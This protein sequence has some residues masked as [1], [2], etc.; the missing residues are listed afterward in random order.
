[1]ICI[2]TYISLITQITSK[3]CIYLQNKSRPIPSLDPSI[4]QQERVTAPP[5]P[6][7]GTQHRS[8]GEG[9]RPSL[10]HPWNPA[11]VS[12]RGSTSLPTPPLEHSIC[13][14]ERVTVPPY[15]TPGTQHLSAGEGHR[16]SLPHPWNPASVSRRGSPSLPTSPLD[17]SICQQERVTVP[18]YLT[19][20]TQ[21]RSAGEGHRPSLPHPWTPASVSRRGSPPLPT[22]PLEP[23]IGQQERVTV[24]P[25]PTPGPQHLSAGQGHRPSLPHPWN[26][27]SVSRRGSPSLPTSP[28]D[29]SICQQERVTVPPYLTPGT[30]HRSAGEGHRSSLSHPWNPASVS[31]KGSPSLPIPPLEPSI[32]QQE[33]VTVPPYPTPGTQHLSAGEGHRPSLSHPW[34]PASVRRKGSPSLPIPPLDPSICQQERVTVP[35]YPTPGPQHQSAGEGHRPSLSHPWNPASVSRRGSPSLP[36]PPLDPSICQQE[37][38]TVPPYPTPGT[39][40]RSA[41]QGHHPS[42]PHPWNPASVSKRGSPSLPTPP[43]DPSICQQERVTVPPYPTPGPQHQSAGEGHRPSLPHPW[44]PASVSRTGS[45]SLP[46][47]PLDPSISQ[48]ERVTVPPSLSH[49]WTPA[50]VSRTGSPSLPI[51]PLEPSICQQERVTVP[52]YP[53]PGTQHLS[54]G[55]GHRPSLPHPWTPAWVSRRGSPSLPTPPL[56]PSIGQ[57]ERVTVPP[58]PTPGTQHLSAGEGH[59]PSL[60]HPWNPAWVSRRGSPS[61]PIPPLEP[62]IC[63]Q[64][65][66]TVPP[67]PTPGT[68]H[69]SAGE[70]HRPSLPHPW[71]PASVSRRGSPSLPTPPLDP[72]ICQQERVTV[73][74][75]PTPGT[76]HLSAGEGHRPS[77]PHP[78]NPASVSRRGSPSLLIPPLD[79]SICQQE[80]VTVPPYPTPGPQ[81]LSAGEGHRP[82]L[83]HPWTPA[84]VSRRGSP[85]LPIPPLDP[86]ICQQERVTVPPYPTPG[87]QHRSAGKGHRPSISHPWNPASV[88][89]RGSP[90]LPIPPLEPSIGQQER[91]TVPPY[92]TPGPQHLSAGE[93]H[94]LSLPHPWTPASVSRRGSPSLPIPPLDP[95]ISQQERVTV[96]PYPTPGTQHLSAGEGH[97]PSL[98]H[99]WNPASV[100]RRGSPSLPTPPLEPSICQQERVTVPPY[101]TPGPQHQSAGE[102]HRPSL[103]HPWNPASVSRRG[104]PSLPIPPLEPSICQQ[105]RVTVPPYP[106][107]GT[108]HLSAGEGHRP[109]LPHPWTPASVSRRG[110]PSLPIPPLE[111]SICQQERVTVPPYPTPGTQHLSAGEGHRPSLSH[112][113]IPASASRRGSPSLP[114]PSLEP[115]I[116]QQE[117]VT[118]PPYPT[119]GNQHLSAREGH[120]PS[121]PHPWNPA[122]A[123]RRGSPS[124]LIPPLDPSIC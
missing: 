94:R 104:S 18:P 51:P 9:H 75:Y 71:N 55:E 64:E 79:P 112:P 57:Q 96:P 82:S 63:Q 43:L 81:H 47:P 86:G 20:G 19:P 109:S 56:E 25:Y 111:P 97:R 21:H 39:Q 85:S 95:S 68:Q 27:A 69:G 61:L 103:P 2:N 17:P 124:L 119:P 7:P 116:C 84:S 59:C 26:P 5:Y 12:R 50:S 37:R 41:G 106:T 120:R 14:Q 13:Q 70:G 76:Q 65:R 115:S 62:S 45:P 30:Q 102:G 40:H 22:P 10:P 15:L 78:W 74:P 32:S 105:E 38:V 48:Q 49:P 36:T 8:A 87:T 60:P 31:R 93:G 121:L 100:S 118:V 54:A 42:L 114:I 92:P 110:S 53:T 80:R 1:M 88:S 44:N 33:R 113:W 91:V 46:T 4:G 73:P 3:L 16:P 34:N 67:Y 6:T 58:Y 101:P 108:Q 107:P 24:P 122:S 117:R 29:P 23:S 66:V 83:S 77:L 123:S 11:S 99:P 72:S 98:S 52:P 90:F 35:P 28:L 89:R